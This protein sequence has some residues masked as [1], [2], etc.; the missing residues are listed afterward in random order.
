MVLRILLFYTVSMPGMN[1]PIP[2]VILRPPTAQDEIPLAADGVY[3][4][5]WESNFG[6][7][8]IEVVDGIAFV[9]GSSVEPVSSSTSTS[10]P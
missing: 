8:L 7:I 9:N 3:R 10:Q 6:D 2:E 1:P 4:V 5:V